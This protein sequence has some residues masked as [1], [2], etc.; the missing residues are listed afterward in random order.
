MSSLGNIHPSLVSYHGLP[1]W[2]DIFRLP[3]EDDCKKEKK[4]P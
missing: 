4:N 2:N 3:D 1:D